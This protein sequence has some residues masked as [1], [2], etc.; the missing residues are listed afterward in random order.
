MIVIVYSENGKI[1]YETEMA[2]LTSKKRREIAMYFT[3]NERSKKINNRNQKLP[4][5]W[6]VANG[7]DCI[8]LRDINGNE[9]FFEYSDIFNDEYSTTVY[10]LIFRIVCNF[11]NIV[12]L[13][14]A[15]NSNM[16]IFTP[17]ESEILDHIFIS[18]FIHLRPK[19]ENTNKN[20]IVGSPINA[21]NENEKNFS[22]SED[23]NEDVSDKINK[24]NEKEKIVKN[25]D[26]INAF[27][28]M[29]ETFISRI[30]KVEE[31]I[32]EKII[33]LEDRY[34][35]ILHILQKQN[36]KQGMFN[37]NTPIE[38]YNLNNKIFSQKD[39]YY[40]LNKIFDCLTV[41]NETDI[42]L[43][44]NNLYS[45]I[46]DII[47]NNN[48]LDIDVKMMLMNLIIY[49]IKNMSINICNTN[50]TLINQQKEIDK[51]KEKINKLKNNE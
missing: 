37:S 38:D 22:E 12:Q 7:S 14:D 1:K 20:D 21:I 19:K 18:N 24:Q 42:P 49:K 35:N 32:N 41:A 51:L 11:K 47:V 40:N 29:L 28:K 46:H 43:I 13:R 16:N 48:Y 27:T 17:R 15:Y 36:Q 44:I 33:K 3:L 8:I 23:N 9:M 31:N 5:N 50:K 34:R 25:N 45:Y 30:D 39:A 2:I 6:K 26:D 4:N 10:G